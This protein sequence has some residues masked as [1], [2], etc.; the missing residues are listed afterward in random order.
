MAWTVEAADVLRAGWSAGLTA[1]QIAVQLGVSRGAVSGKR[2][3]MGL[4]PRSNETRRLAA[5]VNGLRLAAARRTPANDVGGYV[6][7]PGAFE[8]LHGST[9]RPWEQRSFGECAWPVEVTGGELWSCCLPV[10]LTGGPYCQ[11]HQAIMRGDPWPPE[12]P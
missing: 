10:E 7:R 4:P 5:H 11:G 9:P 8:P 12:G 6:E 3:G 1:K 2:H